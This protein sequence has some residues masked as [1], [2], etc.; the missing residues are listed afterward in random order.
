MARTGIVYYAREEEFYRFYE[1]GYQDCVAACAP[2]PL[3]GQIV[4][5]L[6]KK[7]YGVVIATSPLY[8]PIAT[9]SR[10]AWAG[11]KDFHFPLVTT[12]NDSRYAKPNPRYY[13]EVCEKLGV[14]PQACIMVGND[15][16]EDGAA[17]EIGMDVILVTACL[18]NNKN[19][20]L[21][22]FCQATLAEVLRWAQELP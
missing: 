9:H 4:S 3:A 14:S 15:A 19:L 11:L 20:P 10:I 22:G 18:I 17:R 6:Q 13:T 8:P 5:A 21:E 1:E 16:E 2:T 12:F 7:G